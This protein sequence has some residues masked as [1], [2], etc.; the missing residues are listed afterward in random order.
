MTAPD[1]YPMPASNWTSA[2]FGDK[3]ADITASDIIVAVGDFT[4]GTE[5]D[6]FTLTA[7]GLLSGDVVHVLWQSAM[8]A[9]TGG[10][11]TRAIVLW[12]HADRFQLT[13]DGTTVIDNTADGTVVLLKG[14]VPTNVVENMVIP[15][16]I[17]APG[18]HTGGTAEDIFTPA[19]GTKGVFEADPLKMVYKSAAGVVKGVAVNTTVYAKTPTVTYFQVSTSAGGAVLD[20]DAD[21]TAVFLKVA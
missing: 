3:V 5:E 12:K 6:N 21:G 15:R 18:D 16:V 8:G 20:N 1:S 7:H 10:E 2:G 17:V 11:G 9:V 19:Q 4:G 14:R 13:S